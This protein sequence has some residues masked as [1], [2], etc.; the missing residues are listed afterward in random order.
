MKIKG[1]I[2]TLLGGKCQLW[3]WWEYI[4]RVATYVGWQIQ[5]AS[6]VVSHLGG[7]TLWF[8]KVTGFMGIQ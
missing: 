7:R 4:L 1:V 8:L 2:L 3:V 5:S 6:Q